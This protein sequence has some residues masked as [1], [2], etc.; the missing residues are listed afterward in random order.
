MACVTISLTLRK[1]AAD[2][3]EFFA[4]FVLVDERLLMDLCREYEPKTVETLLHVPPE[5]DSYFK[6]EVEKDGYLSSLRGF[7]RL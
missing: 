5:S 2:M 7:A 4:L 6:L 1:Q 3:E